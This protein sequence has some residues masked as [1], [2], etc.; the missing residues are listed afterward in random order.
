MEVY[1]KKSG[2]CIQSISGPNGEGVGASV[3]ADAEVGS[4]KLVAVGTPNKVC[5]MSLMGLHPILQLLVYFVM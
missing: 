5:K 4:G 2:R 3:V 1:H